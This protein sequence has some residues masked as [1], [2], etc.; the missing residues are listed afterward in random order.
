MKGVSRHLF[1]WEAG[2]RVE[3]PKE[4][5]KSDSYL[6]SA[7]KSLF[8]LLTVHPHSAWL[9]KGLIITNINF[10]FRFRGV[11]IIVK[12]IRDN[13]DY[14]VAFKRTVDVR[15]AC[16]AIRR[17]IAAGTQMWKKDQWGGS[18]FDKG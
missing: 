15:T 18:K 14:L 1:G 6:A 16:I 13:K 5:A 17:D 3:D 8:D 12:A 11:M 2:I 10:K 7:E 4:V 9:P